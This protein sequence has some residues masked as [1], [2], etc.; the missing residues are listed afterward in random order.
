MDAIKV[1]GVSR[2]WQPGSG[3]QGQ[4][5]QQRAD[6]SSIG[7]GYNTETRRALVPAAET[8][9]DPCTSVHSWWFQPS[10]WHFAFS[11][12]KPAI[13]PVKRQSGSNRS[14]R[15]KAPAG[16]KRARA[17]PPRP[18]RQHRTRPP[19]LRVDHSIPG[20]RPVTTRIK[21]R[22]VPL[23]RRRR[24]R[25][26]T[27]SQNRETSLLTAK[28]AGREI[29]DTSFSRPKVRLGSRMIFASVA[30]ISQ[31]GRRQ[32]TSIH[33][34]FPPLARKKTNSLRANPGVTAD[35]QIASGVYARNDSDSGR[36]AI[37][38]DAA[39]RRIRIRH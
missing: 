11:R 1:K 19:L 15:P 33:A 35:I 27:R 24:N 5:C 12:C 37:R 28:F 23:R 4:K 6:G 36:I 2:G 10:R 31:P 26:A 29:R 3:S 13:P 34:R 14:E 20:R 7:G 21:G 30:V 17:R 16:R 25:N 39:V 9:G 38:V 32:V 18:G 22:G 8:Q